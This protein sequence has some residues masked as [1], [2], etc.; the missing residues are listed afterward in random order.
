[1]VSATRTAKRWGTL[2]C[3]TVL[4]VL[5]SL[6]GCGGGERTIEASLAL[7][8]TI[9]D[10]GPVSVEMIRIEILPLHP[11][12]APFGDPD[13]PILAAVNVPGR[14]LLAGAAGGGCDLGVCN[15]SL[16]L[17]IPAVRAMEVRAYVFL[18]DY[19]YPVFHANLLRRR[20]SAPG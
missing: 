17:I 20:N 14:D 2:V 12:R 9:G 3:G 6:G 19:E 15:V 18:P 16:N 13:K 11:D 8:V 4:T 7:P 1:M 5:L 10:S